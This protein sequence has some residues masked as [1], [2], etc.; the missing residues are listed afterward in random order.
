MSPAPLAPRTIKSRA[1]VFLPQPLNNKNPIASPAK[2]NALH[3]KMGNNHGC[4]SPRLWTPLMYDSIGQGSQRIRH[5]VQ[6]SGVSNDMPA[7][8]T[9]ALKLK[10]SRGLF[11]LVT[12][13]TIQHM[14]PISIMERPMVF[15][16]STRS[17]SLHGAQPQAM[18]NS[19]RR[20]KNP[21]PRISAPRRI[22]VRATWLAE[23][24]F[25]SNL[26]VTSAKEIPAKN[27]N[28]GAGSVPPI[29]D[30]MKNLVFRA[31]GLSHAS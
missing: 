4:G 6:S 19:W 3:G 25:C 10:M 23:A 24:P 2:A 12:V 5:V 8:T 31:S 26:P 29:C 21:K 13:N 15:S 20:N 14:T 9:T 28:S 16:T 7:A 30:H 27:K 1:P 11:C 18:R 17:R 22:V